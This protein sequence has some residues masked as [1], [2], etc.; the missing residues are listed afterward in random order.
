[1]ET[2]EKL[3]PCRIV[4]LI[5][6]KVL[7]ATKERVNDDDIGVQTINS[8]RKKEV[9]AKSMNP[10]IPRVADRIQ[11]KPREELEEMRTGKRR[12]FVPN[13]HTGVLRAC[14]AW[15]GKRKVLNALGIEMN[16][17]MLVAGKAFQHFCKGAFRAVAAVNKG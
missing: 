16:L 4:D 5:V 9:E 11:E 14:D 2:S 8:R 1:M 3:G 12:D 6:R 15:W 17:A 7:E 13:D 10:P